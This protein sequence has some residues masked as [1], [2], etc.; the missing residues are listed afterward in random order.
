MK[1]AS[2]H[3]DKIWEWL[4]DEARVGP[5]NGTFVTPHFC[6]PTVFHVAFGN[7]EEI[8]LLVSKTSERGRLVAALE[9]PYYVILKFSLTF[10]TL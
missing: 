4:G 7:L 5:G 6:V 8:F 3:G 2:S 9:S 1:L 10:R